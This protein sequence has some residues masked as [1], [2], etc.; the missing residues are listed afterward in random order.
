MELIVRLLGSGVT[1][2]QVRTCWKMR[3]TSGKE[4]WECKP[5]RQ[6]RTSGSNKVIEVLERRISH[7]NYLFLAITRFRRHICDSQTHHAQHQPV[8]RPMSRSPSSGLLQYSF[9][10]RPNQ[11]LAKR[12]H[13]SRSEKRRM[14]KKLVQ[15]F[16]SVLTESNTL[17]KRLNEWQLKRRS[18]GL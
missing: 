12:S 14:E 2:E 7:L 5:T 1:T 3:E 16:W 4:A 18:R 15:L 13:A 10:H 11:K 6:N 17:K 8:L 9:A